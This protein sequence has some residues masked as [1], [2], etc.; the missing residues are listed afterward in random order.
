MKAL[1]DIFMAGD[2]SLQPTIE[3]YIS[4]QAALQ[5]VS[6][7]SGSLTN[8]SGLGEPKFEANGTAFKGAWGRPQ[9]DGPAL[10]ATALIAYARWLLDDDQ[11]S[12]VTSVL[13][14]IIRNDL[15]YI[16]QYWN[17]TGFDLWEE[18]S[19][20]SF[21]TVA[22]QYRA[23]VEGAA[24]AARIDQACPAC[25]SQAPE[26]LCFLQGFW[27]G[28]YIL[29]NINEDNGRTRKDCGSV[30][31]TIQTFDPDAGCDDATFQPCSSRALSNHKVVTDSFR[32]IYGINSGV[33][34]SSAVAVGR[35]P[36]DVYMGGNPWYL[37][38]T[39]AAEQLYNALFQ[40]N[41][42]GSIGVTETSLAFFQPFSSSITAGDYSSSSETFKI[43]I[44]AIK[45][46]ADGY[47]GIVEKNT[48]SNGTLF[49]QFSR[50]DGTPLSAIDLTWSCTSRF[51]SCLLA[52]VDE[53]TQMLQ[54]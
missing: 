13:W 19:G 26:L 17:Q 53:Q 20:S 31:S 51:S 30:L 32:S 36:E 46:Y 21:F 38:T 47:M 35:Y 4:A 23:L 25:E 28:E 39:A 52:A 3:S 29:A 33:N 44:A 1:I 43:L 42:T 6:N 15:S 18:T 27:E 34:N 8:G 10:R 37:C 41:K 22:A 7:P 45:S 12:T 54:S 50:Y 24:L 9:R 48:P 11:P 40:W 49:E 5:S 16:G 14:P 2:R